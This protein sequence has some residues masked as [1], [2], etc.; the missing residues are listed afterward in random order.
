[1][2]FGGPCKAGRV[3]ITI[4]TVETTTKRTDTQEIT[5]AGKSVNDVCDCLNSSKTCSKGCWKLKLR[6]ESDCYLFA[7]FAP[8]L[9]SGFS[10][11]SQR[12]FCDLPQQF[13][14][15]TSA[16]YKEAG[17]NIFHA[18]LA[19]GEPHFSGPEPPSPSPRQSPPFCRESSNCDFVPFR[20]GNWV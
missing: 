19:K 18:Y 4:A 14:V 6:L 15:Q 13:S 10:K 3:P 1:M 5:Y 2:F 9:D 16:S 20:S 7:T 8:R 11:R 17:V 12:N